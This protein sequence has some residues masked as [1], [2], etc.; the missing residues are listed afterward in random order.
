MTRLSKRPSFH[1]DVDSDEDQEMTEVG[2]TTVSTENEISGQ[3]NNAVES[4]KFDI[5]GR[6]ARPLPSAPSVISTATAQSYFHSDEQILK[7]CSES[8]YSFSYAYDC[9]NAMAGRLSVLRKSLRM[10]R[11][12]PV[13]MQE[14]QDTIC[15]PRVAS[16]LDLDLAFVA[17]GASGGTLTSTSHLGSLR[18]SASSATLSF[19][20]NSSESQLAENV[21]SLLSVLEEVGLPESSGPSHGYAYPV[22]SGSHMSGSH[23]N[24]LDGKVKINK[25]DNSLIQLQLLDALS[26]PYVD[27]TP[28]MTAQRAQSVTNIANLGTGNPGPISY[29]ISSLN[30]TPLSVPSGVVKGTAFNVSPLH[31]ISSKYSSAHAVFTTGATSP[32]DVLSLNDM[33]CLIFGKT[34][35][36]M[37]HE[38]ILSIFPESIRPHINNMLSSDGDEPTAE[39]IFCGHVLPVIKSNGCRSRVSIWAKRK[40][41]ASIVSWVLQEVACDKAVL[42]LNSDETIVSYS[43]SS[44]LTSVIGRFENA[45]RSTTIRDFIPDIPEDHALLRESDLGAYKAFNIVPT[46]DGTVIPCFTSVIDANPDITTLEVASFRHIAGAVIIDQKGLKIVDYNVCMLFSLFGYELSSNIRG[47]SVTSIIPQFSQYFS[48]IKRQANFNT[49]SLSAGLVIPEQMFRKIS[50]SSAADEAIDESISPTAVFSLPSV[51]ALTKFGRT[52]HVDI[53]M[54]VVSSTFY[55]LW[56]SYSRSTQGSKDED[57]IEMPSQLNLLHFKRTTDRSQRRARTTSSGASTISPT[58]SDENLR[59]QMSRG[60]S[61][62]T[63]IPTPGTPDDSSRELATPSGTEEMTPSSS[64]EVATPHVIGARRRE[65]KLNDFSVLQTI[66]EGAYGKVLLAQYRTEPKQVVIIKCV[67]KERILVDT[68][69]R[70]RKL[71]TIPNEIKVMATLND[72]PHENIIRLMDFFEDDQYYHIEMERHGDPG[73]D[74]FDLIELKPN[75]PEFEC[76]SIFRQVV[77]AVH[78]LHNQGIVHRDIKDE[79]IIVDGVGQIKLI[80]YGSAAF[81][82]Q[83]PFDI[84]VGTIDYAAPEVLGGRPYEGKP[85]DIWALGILLYTIIYKENPFYNVDEI[86]EGELRIPYVTSQGCIELIQKILARELRNRPTIQDIVNNEWLFS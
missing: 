69:I 60:S 63:S 35:H 68:W 27:I 46:S 58:D 15:V 83:G 28:A 37:R 11:D 43:G 84:F 85:Q 54:R 45:S 77:S 32:F 17:S 24:L 82:R 36:E 20:G 80:D 1:L 65:K 12:N 9:N 72:A 48:E 40:G 73:T 2:T 67:I 7:F 25:S 42:R 23:V 64:E 30:L 4:Q 8:L 61:V 81:V 79:N 33:A 70:D 56:I 66:G 76:K 75:M 18:P 31:P 50:K 55:A 14:L 78:H 53:Q 44:S 86:M 3:V 41:S 51:E 6:F 21:N 16:A 13:M 39:V 49:L 10:I 62:A 74:L 26:V 59:K 34:Q 22:L 38:S 47:S 5:S 52:I 29:N 57:D 71:G 19:L